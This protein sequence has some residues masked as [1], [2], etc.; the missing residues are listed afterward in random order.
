M[1][2]ISDQLF[3]DSQHRISDEIDEGLHYS[4][5]D[6]GCRDAGGNNIILRRIHQM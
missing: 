1:D 5:H 6:S 2:E 3:G 4:L